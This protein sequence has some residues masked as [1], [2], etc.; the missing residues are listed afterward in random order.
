MTYWTALALVLAMQSPI[1]PAPIDSAAID[2]ALRK[3]LVEPPHITCISQDYKVAFDKAR[4]WNQC[5]DSYHITVVFGNVDD[6]KQF[7]LASGEKKSNNLNIQDY[8]DRNGSNWYIC[9]KGYS[10]VDARGQHFKR[11]ISVYL[12]REIGS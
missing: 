3:H 1:P 12:C 4:Y 2:P 9:P 11:I 8:K 5:P 10:A 6:V 7:D